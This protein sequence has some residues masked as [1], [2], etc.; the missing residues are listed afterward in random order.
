MAN[1]ALDFLGDFGKSAP[2]QE[3]Q[4]ATPFEPGAAEEAEHG[5]SLAQV[6]QK[7]A[8]P[9]CEAVIDT[10]VPVSA[11]LVDQVAAARAR[12][13]TTGELV[14]QA[15]WGY[16][17]EAAE[18]RIERLAR[19][20]ML[21]ALALRQREELNVLI[22]RQAVAEADEAAATSKL[23]RYEKLYGAGSSK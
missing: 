10:G 20:D 12:W 19:R 16:T 7:V 22:A 23:A 13:M 2:A 6:A 18:I 9:V 17:D 8:A 1:A 14:G 11:S 5:Q 15:S 21:F 4:E 3:S